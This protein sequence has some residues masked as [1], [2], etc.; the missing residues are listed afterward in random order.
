MVTN[1]IKRRTNRL[2]QGSF[3]VVHLVDYQGAQLAV[4][5]FINDLK[6]MLAE[7]AE[8]ALTQFRMIQSLAM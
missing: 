3:G 2:G 1:L 6:E 4:K 5:E 7:D 8:I